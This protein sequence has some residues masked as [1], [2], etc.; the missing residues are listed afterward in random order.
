MNNALLSSDDIRRLAEKQLPTQVKW[1]RHLHQ[2]P[3]TANQEFET[4]KFL[5]QELK[6][7]GLKI[8]PLNM[9]TGVLAELVGGKGP[10]VAIR[11]DID[12]LPMDEKT[13]LKFASKNPGRMH[14]CG[15]DAHMATVLGTAA[16][17][18]AERKRLNGSVRFLF[19]PSEEDPPGGAR[20]MIDEGA[21]K[22]V[23]VI[24]GL[25]V[26]PTLPT[27]TIGLCDGPM[28]AMVFDFDLI[29]K[30]RGSHAARPQYSVD[31]VTVAAEVVG[32]LQTLVSRKIDPSTPLVIT[33]G[34]VVAGTARNVIAREARLVCTARAL[35]PALGKKIHAMIKKTVGGICRAHGATF[36]IERSPSYP[37]L[38]ND[39]RVNGLYRE[40]FGRL[41]GASKVRPAE[42][43]LGG[44]DFAYYLQKVPGA[45]L[46]LGMADKKAG[47]GQP[48]HASDF[49]VDERAI[50]YGTSLMVGATLEY[51][52]KKQL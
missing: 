16:I 14:A 17:L 8:L 21:L 5:K 20:F 28:M 2:Y 45:M 41:H 38:I 34:Q 31:A 39:A 11:S 50:Y 37:I 40:V 12:A 44:E 29:I 48:W 35:S 36:E 4:T 23:D 46:R 10:C 32:A 6:K 42:A 25:H 19:Q 3:E 13:G 43:V 47:S 18:A 9:K 27:G 52:E 24:F 22:G 7:L 51:M 33:I 15:H 30:G 49:R 1:R 26:E